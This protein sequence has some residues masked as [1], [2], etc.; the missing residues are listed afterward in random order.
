M[1]GSG[2]DV[3]RFARF[4]PS[5]FLLL[6][7]SKKRFQPA[8]K[9][10]PEDR[11]LVAPSLKTT[12]A[13]LDSRVGRPVPRGDGH[14]APPRKWVL[15]RVAG[16]PGG[17]SHAD[18]NEISPGTWQP[19]QRLRTAALLVALAV[20]QV[21]APNHARAADAARTSETASALSLRMLQLRTEIAEH[22]RRYH[23]DATPAISD[24]DY[25]RLKREL[26]DLEAAFPVLA[27]SLGAWAEL[28]DDRSGLF[29]TASHREPMLSLEK[30]YS[31]A[32]LRAFD[33]RVSRQ[34][35]GGEVEYL[36]EP[37]Y[38]GFAISLTYEQGVLVRAVTRGNGL[39]GDDL[40]SHLA[41]L[42]D[43]PREL[44]EL[45]PDGRPNPIPQRIEIRGEVFV[46]SEE[47]ARY[48]R[49][50]EATGEP[51]VT[52]P[53]SL[54]VAAM[55]RSESEAGCALEL[56]CYAFGECEPISMLPPTQAGWHE[57]MRAWGMPGVDHVWAARGPLEVIAAVE[58]VRQAR[59]NFPFPTD[60]AVVKLN[61][62]A[63]QQELG[64]SESAPRW[65]IAY[66][67]APSRRETQ[68]MGITVQ[69]GRTGV[70]TPVAELAP[71]ELD[72]ATIRRATLHNRAEI[73]R[74]DVRVGDFVEIEKAGEIIPAIV[75]LNLAKRPSSAIPYEF[76]QVC[77][78][79][80]MPA[81]SRSGEVAIRCSNFDC[82]AQ[83]RRR[84]EYFASKEGVEIA[85]LGPATIDALVSLGGVREPA[86][87]YRLKSAD[88]TALGSD[89][90]AGQIEAAIAASRTAELWRFI[91]GLGLPHVGTVT[92][93]ELA[94]RYGSLEALANAGAKEE[95][96][97]AAVA[98]YLAEPRQRA[99]LTALIAVG[100]Q[101]RAPGAAGSG[102]SRVAGKVFVLTGTLDS[103]TRA[104]ATE[105]I[106]AAGGT[107][108]SAM[109]RGV[110]F[111][112]VGREPGAK[113]EQARAA[114]VTEIGEAE[115]LE[116]LTPSEDPK[117]AEAGN[118]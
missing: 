17:R 100:V 95:K 91:V 90:I 59:A 16:T 28:G 33:R 81:E 60:G 101:P 78:S 20:V 21:P 11:I 93:R 7:F 56:V 19:K 40:T 96:V 114:G 116:M 5:S 18:M 62:L 70:L 29:R 6:T 50:R 73:A 69:V 3:S 86:D 104:Q 22:D 68:L 75:G 108:K 58:A 41:R 74:R 25:D 46:T 9:N 107:V 63:G 37:K 102:R 36:I 55:R 47:F 103:L 61:S 30:A 110:D 117:T 115:L 39:E 79:C 118:H 89:R 32:E 88:L 2:G 12:A 54:A 31:E 43:C 1:S 45:G 51:L 8:P 66:K 65:A 94:R 27:T 109:T 42:R 15:W 82:P 98:A 85:G 87:L 111:L 92:A 99:M 13:E 34:L 67:F 84:L 23:R 48:N 52:T 105:K 24:S 76:P 72:G 44:R 53:R 49:E 57:R 112:I 71:V 113:R 97:P 10:I 4:L 64:R 83:V 35:G 106:E 80:G 77:P 26:R 38:D 14:P